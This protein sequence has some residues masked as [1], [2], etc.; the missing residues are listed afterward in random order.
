MTPQAIEVWRIVQLLHIVGAK[1]MMDFGLHGLL[2]RIERDFGARWAKILTILIAMAIVA[3]CLTIVGNL[4]SAFSLW[5]SDITSESTIWSKLFVVLK[6][7]VGLGL[8]VTVA[9]NLVFAKNMKNLESLAR[10]Y[11][12]DAEEMIKVAKDADQKTNENIALLGA[13]VKDLAEATEDKA[14]AARLNGL[15]DKIQDHG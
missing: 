12:F 5:M 13:I 6:Y 11:A 3:G 14:F 8:I 9:N 10:K 4:I 15:H 1:V 2:D 7:A